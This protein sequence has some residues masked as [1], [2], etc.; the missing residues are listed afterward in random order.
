MAAL[1]SYIHSHLTASPPL[2]CC[3]RFRT[4]ARILRQGYNLMFLD[5]D[6]VIFQDPYK[7]FKAEPLASKNIMFSGTAEYS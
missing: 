5:T 3:A 4:A 2:A 7:H 6:L 1:L